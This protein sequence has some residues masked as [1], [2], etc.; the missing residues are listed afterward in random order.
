MR[1]MIDSILVISHLSVRI[2]CKI[3]TEWRKWK[4]IKVQYT[5]VKDYEY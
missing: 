2:F 3:L 5:K 1:K 4:E